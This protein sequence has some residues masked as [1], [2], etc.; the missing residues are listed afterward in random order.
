ML[1]K[2]KGR[3][4]GRQ[5][6]RGLEG[7]TDSMDKSLGGLWELVV[8]RE[9]WCAAIHGVAEGEMGVGDSIAKTTDVLPLEG[10][11]LVALPS[12][13]AP[14]GN[15]EEE[16]LRILW[17]RC[18]QRHTGFTV[19]RGRGWREAPEAATFSSVETLFSEHFTFATN[20]RRKYRLFP[21]A[22]CPPHGEFPWCQ[23]PPSAGCTTSVR[24]IWIRGH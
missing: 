9:A 8:D 10:T 3:R 22:S 15:T 21:Y 17:T 19:T 20:L 11:R 1:G 23:Q 12:L 5:R 14:C 16:H 2:I 13:P 18:G 6:M 24:S 7:I 4:R